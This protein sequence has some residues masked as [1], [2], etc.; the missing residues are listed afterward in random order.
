MIELQHANTSTIVVYSGPHEGSDYSSVKDILENPARIYTTKEGKTV[1][2]PFV[3][4][5]HRSL[6]RIVDFFP[7]DIKQFSKRSPISAKRWNWD[8]WL[9]V[10]DTTYNASNVDDDEQ[11]HEMN[12]RVSGSDATTF[13]GL[14]AGDLTT[15][16]NAKLLNSLKEKLFLLWGELAEKKEKFSQAHPHIKAD[17]QFSA[18]THNI[19]TD[20]LP[21]VIGIKEVG[22]LRLASAFDSSAYYM[23]NET[24]IQ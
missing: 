6:V 2:M 24:K 13:L 22:D 20:S 12:L 4:I 3:N 1:E 15:K 23:I 8:F 11:A 14:M 16:A 18:I 21:C 10:R 17:D 19:T 7:H 9:V 5:K